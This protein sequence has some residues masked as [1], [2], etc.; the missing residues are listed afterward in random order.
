[1]LDD[2]VSYNNEMVV[3]RDN[4]WYRFKLSLLLL[5]NDNVGY[6]VSFFFVMKEYLVLR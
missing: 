3:E 5:K 1:M 4:F 2:E 6:S